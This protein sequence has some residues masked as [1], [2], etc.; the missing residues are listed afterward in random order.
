MSTRP[1][2]RLIL[3]GLLLVAAACLR[4]GIAGAA[5]VSS[6][7]A[8]AIVPSNAPDLLG[9]IDERGRVG[10]ACRPEKA[11]ESTNARMAELPAIDSR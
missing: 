1:F 10:W 4:I 5:D 7:A 8:D 3:A 2:S 11:A 6:L 9:P